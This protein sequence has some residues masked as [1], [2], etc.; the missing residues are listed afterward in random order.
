MSEKEVS[1]IL[2]GVLGRC[3]RCGEGRLFDGFISLDQSCSSCDLDYDF[4]DSGDGPAVFIMLIVGFLVVGLAIYTEINYRPDYWV[5]AVL[6]LPSILILSA[7]FLRPLKGILI[8]LQYSND[9]REGR[10]TDD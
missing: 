2:A 9:A 5:H 7:G 6:W 3:P 8:C 10:K 4:A 1:P